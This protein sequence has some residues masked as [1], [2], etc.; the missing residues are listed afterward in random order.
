MYNIPSNTNYQKSKKVNFGIEIL[1]MIMAFWVVLNHCYKTKNEILHNI[2]FCHKFHVPTFIIISFYFYYNSLSLKN[3]NK[4]KSRLEKLFWPYLIYPT[5]IW[6]INYLLNINSNQFIL[7]IYYKKLIMQFLIGRG[8]YGVLWFHFNLIFLTI[9]FFILSFMVNQH[10][11]LIL[12]I[13]AIISYITQYSNFNYNF[14]KRY[15]HNVKYS[16][17]YF[18]E[19]FPLAVTGLTFAS[20]N[21]IKAMREIRSKIVFFSIVL[22]FLLFK[23]NIFTVIKGYG[24]A[25]FMLNIG[26][27]LFFILFYLL[28]IEKI[29]ISIILLIIK[30][31]LK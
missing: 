11:L 20:L 17:G 16:V 23:Y 2:I 8:V 9:L 28:P 6:F 24:K 18:A 10:Y 21:I 7:K 14:F 5:F 4:I 1:R 26:A 29:K 3:I 22:I 31:T 13:L 30:Y 12:Q 19:T 25:G 15:K 27:L